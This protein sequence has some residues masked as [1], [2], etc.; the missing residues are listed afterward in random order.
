MQENV[1][2]AL[3][4]HRETIR[5][6][7]QHKD[8]QTEHTPI[9]DCVTVVAEASQ[10][11]SSL[12]TRISTVVDGQND[13][14]R[15]MFDTNAETVKAAMS[16]WR[17]AIHG[18][19][20]K[21]GDNITNS[22]L[23]HEIELKGLAQ[24]LESQIQ[25]GR[26]MD[27]RLHLEI[28]S[29]TDMVAHKDKTIT[30]LQQKLE[31]TEKT[32][33][34]PLKTANE[35]KSRELI[36]VKQQ[37]TQAQVAAQTARQRFTAVLKHNA[38]AS[39]AAATRLQRLENELQQFRSQNAQLQAKL[40]GQAEAATTSRE[41]QKDSP[42]VETNMNEGD[43]K[44]MAK[45]EAE[46][47]TLRSAIHEM[48]KAAEESVERQSLESPS[49][50]MAEVQ[51]FVNQLTE[52]KAEIKEKDHTIKK[53]SQQSESQKIDKLR[54]LCDFERNRCCELQTRIG[55]L[56]QRIADL[57]TE[58]SN[59][60]DMSNKVRSHL[61]RYLFDPDHGVQT[62]RNSGSKVERKGPVSAA[63]EESPVLMNKPSVPSSS[64]ARQP[65]APA[66]PTHTTKA[67]EPKPLHKAT[68]LDHKH[69][70]TGIEGRRTPLLW[71]QQRLQE[72]AAG[73]EKA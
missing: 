14:L 57:E 64:V 2:P 31:E 3:T 9:E 16:D 39:T 61:N 56:Q 67:D 62:G 15:D 26:E 25:F 37:F 20:E 40:M 33:V 48:R 53:L 59:L 50:P 21:F 36:S 11:I 63:A 18:I 27:E 6:L 19:Q 41:S 71:I 69:S 49:L 5:Q 60:M 7:K 72:I 10:R 52:L 45:M 30:G 23:H 58:R 43:S 35:I 4:E 66:L 38:Q 68:S 70:S 44:K 51:L 54:H 73:K 1:T 22:K 29:L 46:N 32:I 47:A 24:N 12:E 55:Q 17:N 28:A 13:R 34:G 42:A 65:P 8:T